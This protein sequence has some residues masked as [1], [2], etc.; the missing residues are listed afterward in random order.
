MDLQITVGG[1]VCVV[2]LQQT[3]LHNFASSREAQVQRQALRLHLQTFS[4][5]CL[6]TIT[7]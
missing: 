2:L 7:L 4:S 6:R 5:V 1:S 3:A